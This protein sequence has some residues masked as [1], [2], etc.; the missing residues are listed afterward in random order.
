MKTLFAAAFLLLTALSGHGQTKTLRQNN[1][2]LEQHLNNLVFKEGGDN[3]RF[4]FDDCD[5]RM[6]IG[7]KEKDGFNM[8][9]NF[10]CALSQIEQVS[11]RKEDEGYQLKLRLK[12]EEAD[13][14]NLS[15]SLATTDEKLM[16]EIKQRLETSIAACKSG[17]NGKLKTETG[18]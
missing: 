7:V 3:A 2:W 9:M 6:E 10:G 17:N 1:E 15:F 8:G 13:D 5:A 4:R 16:Q 18:K 12:K 14:N 11:Y